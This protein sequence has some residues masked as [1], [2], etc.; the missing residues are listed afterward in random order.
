M[1]VSCS[2]KTCI[3]SLLDSISVNWVKLV[4]VFFM[5]SISLPILCLLVLSI[6]DR[7]MLDAPTRIVALSISSLSSVSFALCILKL[8]C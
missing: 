3:V 6:I 2:L 1:I 4:I 8:S 5:L 7:G